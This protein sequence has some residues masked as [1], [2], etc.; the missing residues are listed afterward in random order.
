[1][2]RR[3]TLVQA[4]G[5]ALLLGSTG[6][7]LADDRNLG[8]TVRAV[9]LTGG[10]YDRYR[11]ILLSFAD[12][13]RTLGIID[14]A[15]E[16]LDPGLN[17]TADV[18]KALNETAGGSNIRFLADGHYDCMFDADRR[19]RMVAELAERVATAKDVDVIFV[20]GTETTLEVAE[21][22][23][24]IP[25]LSLA[26][27]DP[28]ATGIVLS[29]DD[30]GQD[31]LHALVSAGYFRQQVE[32]FHSVRPFKSLGF[33]TAEQRAA[34]SGVGD[35]R[36]ACVAK[37]ITLVD[38]YYDEDEEKSEAA[39]FRAFYECLEKL[40]EKGIEAVMLPWFPCTDAELAQVVALL[41]KHGVW[42]YSLAGPAFTSRGILLGAGEET[43]ESYGLFE[44]DVLRRV[45]DGDMP[46][47]ISQIF[48][49]PNKLSLNLRTAMQ[50]GWHVPFG[51]LV[52]V[53]KTYTTQSIEIL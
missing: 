6:A 4:A 38:A 18:W 51:L 37:G 36:A 14:R 31:N 30:S 10:D 20:F 43:L 32:S 33:V 48:V 16:G 42:S 21:A 15:P 9:L 24:T 50:M 47:E 13:L 34:K 41:V 25:V 8:R 35:V 46:R 40:V 27:T 23:K 26:S 28:V 3:R 5:L 22:V 49:Q 29:A 7:A 2:M 17:G 52:S 19:R 53:E 12:G 1:M 45:I 39:R 44:A 11:R